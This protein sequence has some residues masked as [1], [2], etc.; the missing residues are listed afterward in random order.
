MEWI[1]L[2]WIYA[3]FPHLHTQTFVHL[4]ISIHIPALFYLMTAYHIPKRWCRRLIHASTTKCKANC[5]FLNWATDSYKPL[6]TLFHIHKLTDS[7]DGLVLLWLTWEKVCLASLMPW[8]LDE[9]HCSI[10]KINQNLFKT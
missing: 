10:L 4:P 3:L 1:L 8:I 9:I 7:H 6:S 5:M 2:I